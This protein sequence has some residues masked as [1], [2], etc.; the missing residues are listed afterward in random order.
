MV[1]S[2]H[3]IFDNEKQFM[4]V[5]WGFFCFLFF[6]F[7]DRKKQFF[8]V[9]MTGKTGSNIPVGPEPASALIRRSTTLLTWGAR[10]SDI[11]YNIF[12]F[13]FVWYLLGDSDAQI[14]NYS[15]PYIYYRG[16]SLS[17]NFAELHTKVFLQ[18][19]F[20]LHQHYLCWCLTLMW[21]IAAFAWLLEE[22]DWWIDEFQSIIHYR[23][24]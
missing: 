20:Y 3:K 6:C 18:R 14:F 7:D 13:H 8:V 12:D 4:F 11:Q 5:W 22:L 16:L 23:N 2:P 10:Y 21:K 17:G 24:K 15:I 19:L 1:S 9:G